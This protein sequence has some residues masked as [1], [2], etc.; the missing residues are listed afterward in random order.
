MVSYTI[1][2]LLWML[3]TLGLVSILAFLLI[4]LAPGDIASEIAGDYASEESI[5]TIRENLGLNRPLHIQYIEFIRKLLTGELNSLTARTG[6]IQ[7]ILYKLPVT[8]SIALGSFIVALFIGIP[9]GF[10]SAVWENS[11]I[12]RLGMVIAT[13]GVS[14]PAFWL[15]MNLINWFA[16]KLPW[17]PSGGFVHITDDVVG[18]VRS[19]TLPSI[20]LG[21]AQ[22]ALLARMT[23]SSL[24]EVLRDDYVRTARAKGLNE[25]T[26]IVKHALRNSIITIVT[27]VGLIFGILLGGSVITEQV[28]TL[29]G[30]GRLIVQAVARRDYPTVQGI[31]IFVAFVY[32]NVNLLVDLTYAFLDPRIR[33]S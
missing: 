2:R 20:S 3:V 19:I 17:L 32:A 8:A 15:G 30:V 27:V 4:H 31:L 21:F 23:R 22:A 24:L 11:W 18:W 29:P 16:I 10:A 28:Y 6:V 5:E 33:Y 14:V 13:V 25:R 7:I 12:D 26:V 1:R 9:L